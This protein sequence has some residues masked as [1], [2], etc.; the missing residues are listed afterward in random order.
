VDERRATDSDRGRRDNEALFAKWDLPP[1]N[2]DRNDFDA[3][4]P[5][6]LRGLRMPLSAAA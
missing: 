3:A 6:T 1:R 4:Y 5:C 2:L